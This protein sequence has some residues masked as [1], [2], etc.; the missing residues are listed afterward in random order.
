[1]PRWSLAL[2]AIP[3]AWLGAAPVGAQ[4]A[5]DRPVSIEFDVGDHDAA[6]GDWPITVVRVSGDLD[7][8]ELFVVEL[9]DG[10]GAVLWAGEAVYR[11]PTTSVAVD[12]F[13]AVG[14]V[15]EAAI[16]QRLPPT[17]LPAPDE[18][19]APVPIEEPEVARE[20]VTMPDPP[21]EAVSPTPRVR[22]DVVTRPEPVPQGNGFGGAGQLALSMVIAVVFVAI[23]FRTPLPSATT[24]RWRK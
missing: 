6:R 15:E 3:L 7:V 23:L 8:G 16:G 22:G 12:Q 4:T 11:P 17:T 18:P 1:M 5:E 14:D 20:V 24:M 10:D 2:V 19:E 21:Q 9:R 13:V